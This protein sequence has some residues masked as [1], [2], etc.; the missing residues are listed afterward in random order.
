VYEKQSSII[1]VIIVFVG[2]ILPLIG[3]F[4][5]L[6]TLFGLES[7]YVPLYILILT[8]N[9]PLFY[10]WLQK[11]THESEDVDLQEI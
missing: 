11:R 10:L 3:L 5:I 4:F 6:G 2:I 7:G 8:M 1:K 9:T